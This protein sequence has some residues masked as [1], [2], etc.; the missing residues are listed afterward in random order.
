MTGSWEDAEELTQDVFSNLYRSRRK[1]ID[2]AKFSTLLW[3]IAIN[4]CR[5]FARQKDRRSKEQDLELAAVNLRLH[6]RSANHLGHAIDE[7]LMSLKPIY[8]EVIV[9]RH[10]ENLKFQ[11]IAEM[12][13]VPAGTVASRMAAGLKQIRKRL[14]ASGHVRDE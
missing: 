13:D 11:E 5:D 3:K 6:D 1:Y 4:R 14:R 12:L 10:Y 2:S 9:L 8:R 7:A